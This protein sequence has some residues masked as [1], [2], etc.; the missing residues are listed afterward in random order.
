LLGLIT[1]GT[2]FVATGLFLPSMRVG[3]SGA[4]ATLMPLVSTLPSTRD[5]SVAQMLG[6]LPSGL[7]AG[8]SSAALWVSAV[9]MGVFAIGFGLLLPVAMVLGLLVMPKNSPRW[10]DAALSVVR[11]CSA[12][13]VWMVLLAGCFLELEK[14]SNY[15]LA[16]FLGP[17]NVLLSAYPTVF[18]STVVFS[19]SVSPIIGYWFLVAGCFVVAP[20]AVVV[21]SLRLFA[22]KQPNFLYLGALKMGLVETLPIPAHDYE[23]LNELE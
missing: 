14:M 19:T 22:S 16:P 17:F 23:P 4:A 10:F 21:V 11:T 15:L 6:E 3:A 5:Y 1:V 9:V 2:A 13:E 12:A 20:L 7:P 8:W 18:N